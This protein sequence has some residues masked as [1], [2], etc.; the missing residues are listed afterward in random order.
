[1][2]TLPVIL[3][4]FEQ[5]H[6]CGTIGSSMCAALMKRKDPGA[7]V[8]LGVRSKSLR[9]KITTWLLVPMAIILVAMVL[10]SMYAYQQTAEELT[11]TR[12]IELTSAAAHQLNVELTRGMDIQ[13]VIRNWSSYRRSP[14]Y[15]GVFVERIRGVMA[16]RAG[17]DGTAYI[18]DGQ[19]RV[20]YD[21]DNRYMGSDFSRM[22][23][24]QQ[25]LAGNTGAMRTKDLVDQ[26]IIAS[27]APIPGTPW[28]LVSEERW[29][30]LIRTSAQ[31]RQF[32]FLLLLLGL[33]VPVLII[34]FGVRRVTQPIASMV[35]ASVEI[36]QGHFEQRIHV[37]SGDELEVLAWQFNRMAN[38]LQ[39][40]YALM[41]ERIVERTHAI[42]TLNNIVATANEPLDLPAKLAIVLD[43]VM[44]LLD[45]EVGEIR[46]PGE[47]EDGDALRLQ[48]GLAE[49]AERPEL[50]A[51]LDNLSAPVLLSREP[52][53]AED[54]R[55]DPLQGPLAP[56]RLL[57][58]AVLPI[59][60]KDKLLGA[61]SLAT[62]RGPR[63]FDAQDRRLLHAISGQL[64][65][66]VENA[67]LYEEA[68]QRAVIEER[69]RLAR[70]LHD[71]VTQSL[72]GVTLYA[73]AASR[74]LS[75]G[76]VSMAGDYLHELRATALESLRELR[77]LIFELRPSVLQRD[78][79]VP[80]IMA[81]L[82]AV[83][84]RGELETE[85]N[86]DGESD[87]TPETAEG[88]YRIAQEALNNACKHAR[89]R[90][91]V[92]HL[93][94]EPQQVILE[95]ADDG[96]GFDPVQARAHGGL[97]LYGMEE[98]ATRLG[99]R[100]TVLSAPGQGTRVRV[101]VDL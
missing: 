25:V 72:Y 90:R 65:V 28:G 31:Y 100:L 23:A 58:L 83:E 67:N 55:M 97:G 50:Q 15:Q 53:I 61:L 44:E 69:N 24:V 98:R 88:L 80:A 29:E 14:A 11:F 85:F 59:Q 16:L 91:I 70:E 21:P 62:R 7:L 43:G 76:E 57:A 73:E 35:R 36:A 22:P 3:P 74:L 27:Y 66:V 78:G 32:L 77:S 86:V 4:Y 81:R 96:I 99:G 6:S 9:A 34:T 95:V 17:Q 92:V 20:I 56:L 33:I 37:S 60:A 5:A 54:L 2:Y 79:L 82:E 63:T 10:F 47:Q 87:L 48:R 18:V 71:S 19:G 13:V 93:Q 101:E 40:S 89:A 38:A 39:E 42:E 84:G 41:E 68:R 45:M 94:Q 52:R 8:E 49:L 26:D 12:D 46:L 1:M 51:A 64:G 75:A 30:T